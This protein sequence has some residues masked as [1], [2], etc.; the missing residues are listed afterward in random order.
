MAV[1]KGTIACG[2]LVIKDRILRDQLVKQ[3]SVLCFEIEAVGVSAD[4]FCII[5]CEILDYSDSHKNN[6]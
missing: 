1:Y 4:F 6:R 3:D 2:E 5:I